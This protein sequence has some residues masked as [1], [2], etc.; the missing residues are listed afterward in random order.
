M[1]QNG[2][3]LPLYL[4]L[5]ATAAFALTGA[6]A[7]IKRGYDVVGGFALALVTSIG[8][9]LMRDGLLIQ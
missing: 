4:D 3:Q 8:G 2:F 9:A 5:G 7:A 6:L 1:L